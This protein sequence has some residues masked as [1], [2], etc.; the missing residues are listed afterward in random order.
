MYNF[1]LYFNIHT[2]IH[3]YIHTSCK[4]HPVRVSCIRDRMM[5]CLGCEKMQ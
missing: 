1:I 4:V 5:S 2:Y 3:T